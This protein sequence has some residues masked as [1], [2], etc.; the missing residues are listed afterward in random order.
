MMPEIRSRYC[1][2]IG[3]ALLLCSVL[4][5]V[6]MS[7]ATRAEQREL[8]RAESVLRDSAH[9]SPDLL[10]ALTRA[11]DHLT[12]RV[13]ASL[14]F[15]P[16]GSVLT[17]EVLKQAPLEAVLRL[18]K[19]R[20]ALAAQI[21][22]FTDD[23]GGVSANQSL[24]AARAKALCSTFSAA[25]IPAARLFQHGGG[26]S[27]A[28]SSNATPEGR[29]ENRRVEITIVPVRLAPIRLAPATGP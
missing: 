3:L 9:Q 23:I 4:P 6:A 27:E 11:D 17:P 24:S 21:A 29:Q 26:A 10:I 22:V 12:L 19:R 8:D 20:R 16:D 5:A 2:W 18:L 1:N 25:G 15:E 14:L 28:L 7:A 13:A